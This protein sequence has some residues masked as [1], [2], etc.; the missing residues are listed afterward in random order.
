MNKLIY[1]VNADDE[2]TFV[3][4]NWVAFATENGMCSPIPEAVVGTRLWKHISDPTTRHLYSIF[5][6]KVRKSKQTVILPFRC[7]SPS[8]R[9]YMEMH[10]VHLSATEL[11]FKS[12]LV[13]EE[14][15]SE[16]KL[17]DPKATRSDK[18][19]NMC[20]WCKRVKASDW[21]EVEDALRE[22]NLFDTTMLPMISHVVCPDCNARGLKA[23]LE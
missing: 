8:V 19:I 23:V 13:R 4:S 11:E 7:D 1:R 9:R 20:V 16:V 22:L 2:I 18:L 6:E 17:L 3:D 12:V 21:R 10:I 15:R 5:L 14:P